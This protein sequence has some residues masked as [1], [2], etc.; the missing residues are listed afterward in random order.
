[1]DQLVVLNREQPPK[2]IIIFDLT[3]STLP[4]QDS[5]LR[6][7]VTKTEPKWPRTLQTSA[8]QKG[9]QIFFDFGRGFRRRRQ[10]CFSFG[11]Q[12]NGSLRLASPIL[13]WIS[14]R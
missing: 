14:Q 8:N 13:S 2:F 4:Q 1:M 9:S 3:K 10:P 6:P 12:G 7:S 11:S 5:F